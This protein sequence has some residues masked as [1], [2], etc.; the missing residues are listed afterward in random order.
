MNHMNHK[1]I[2]PFLLLGA[3]ACQMAHAQ[4]E[5]ADLLMQADSVNA[6]TNWGVTNDVPDKYSSFRQF[7]P[8][9]RSISVFFY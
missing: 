1:I 9:L 7:R 2:A 8:G 6:I 5:N 4:I 3:M